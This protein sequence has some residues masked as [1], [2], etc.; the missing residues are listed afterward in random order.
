MSQRLRAAA[1]SGFL[2]FLPVMIAADSTPDTEFTEFSG[3]RYRVFN[4][5]DDLFWGDARDHC[6][7]L[8]GYLVVVDREEEFRFIAELCDGRYLYLGA[9]DELEEANWAWV[10]V[11]ASGSGFWMPTGYICEWDDSGKPVEESK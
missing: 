11:T 9:S 4:D 6:A 7:S 1:L 3:H 2:V 5:V 8:G 10:D